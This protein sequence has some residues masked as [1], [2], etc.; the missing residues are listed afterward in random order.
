MLEKLKHLPIIVALIGLTIITVTGFIKYN[1]LVVKLESINSKTIEEQ[2][3]R[4]EKQI[5][6]NQKEIEILKAQIKELKIKST[7]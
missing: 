2:I 3:N 4:V 7:L 6:I 1:E 5:I